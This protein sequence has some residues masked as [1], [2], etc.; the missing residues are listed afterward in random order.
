[1]LVFAAA[2][3][4]ACLPCA[5]QDAGGSIEESRLRDSEDSRTGDRGIGDGWWRTLLA[6]GIVV[7]LVFAARWGLRKLTGAAG[8]AAGGEAMRIVAR[9]NVSGRQQILLVHC[10]RRL[11][12]VGAGPEGM[13]TLSEITDEEEVRRMLAEAKPGKAFGDL[14]A[15]K[16]AEAKEAGGK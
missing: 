11:L 10:G 3:T 15:G 5:A 13:N 6:L 9:T 12:V 16:R 1:M 2:L 14:L 4:A 7:G 8:G